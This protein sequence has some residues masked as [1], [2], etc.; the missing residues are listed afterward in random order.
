MQPQAIVVP[1]SEFT[2]KSPIAI[3]KLIDIV[4]EAMKRQSGMVE[5]TVS[6]ES[7]HEVDSPWISLKSEQHYVF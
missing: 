4:V 7:F 1:R 6:K 2:R 3:P 5:S